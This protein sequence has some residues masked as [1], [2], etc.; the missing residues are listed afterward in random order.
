MQARVIR[1][2]AM[3]L[4]DGLKTD[5]D[6]FGSELFMTRLRAGKRTR[7]EVENFNYGSCSKLTDMIASKGSTCPEPG[8]VVAK[9]IS[10]CRLGPA[11]RIYVVF[12]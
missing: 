7:S 6:N 5:P 11:S 8:N 1:H 4:F 12:L 3:K 2:L 9:E 10:L